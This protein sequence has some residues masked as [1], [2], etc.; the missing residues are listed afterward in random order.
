MSPIKKKLARVEV[1]LVSG[2]KNHRGYTEYFSQ[3]DVYIKTI[4]VEN[5]ID[6]SAGKIFDVKFKSSSGE[7]VCLNCKIKWSYKTPP[8]GLTVSVGMD[9]IDPPA[10]YREFFKNL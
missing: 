5:P 2:E 1:E 10:D 4:P 3:D 9:I 7:A 8:H 6:Y